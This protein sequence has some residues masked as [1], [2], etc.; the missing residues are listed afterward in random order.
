MSGRK[1]L[2]LVA[3]ILVISVVGVIWYGGFFPF[4]VQGPPPIEVVVII[5][6]GSGL[7]LQLGFKPALVKLVIG[8]NNTVVWK[9][10][11]TTWHTAHSNIPEFDS[12]MIPA[13]A[14]FTHTFERPGSYPYHCDPHPWM[15]GLVVVQASNAAGITQLSIPRQ[16]TGQLLVKSCDGLEP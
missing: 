8:V 12:K 5:Q 15:T 3:L 4:N 10:E 2:A 13:G 6:R 7:N 9:N 1:N 11:D 14:N 16:V